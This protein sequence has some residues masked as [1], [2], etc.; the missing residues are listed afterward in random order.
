MSMTR[1]VDNVIKLITKCQS[2]EEENRQLRTKL[3]ICEL[4]CDGLEKTI[5]TLVEENDMLIEETHRIISLENHKSKIKSVFQ[6]LLKKT[7]N[8]NEWDLVEN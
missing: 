2:L 8:V 5:D 1:M 4:A 3:D 6:E 7:N